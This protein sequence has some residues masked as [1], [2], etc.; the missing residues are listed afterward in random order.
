MKEI[1]RYILKADFTYR[2]W[3][4]QNGRN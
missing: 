4:L 1:S 3:G 2:Y